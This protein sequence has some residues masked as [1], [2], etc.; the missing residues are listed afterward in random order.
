MKKQ[1]LKCLACFLVISIAI[2]LLIFNRNMFLSLGGQEQVL[3]W[4]AT[5][6]FESDKKGGYIL[7]SGKTGTLKLSGMKGELGYMYIDIGA[8]DGDG[9]TAPIEYALVISDEGNSE[10]YTLPKVNMYP[11]IEKTKYVCGDSYGDVK[12]MKIY[13]YAKSDITVTID[14]IAYNVKVPCFFS[15]I[16]VI[17][18][19]SIMMLLWS[20]RPTSGLYN[21]SWDRGIKA[22]VVFSVLIINIAILFVLV[23]SNVSFLDPGWAHHKQYHKLAVA[24]TKGEVSIPIGIEDEISKLSNPY[25][26]SLR[27][28]VKNSSLGW[29]T[30]FYE[31]KFYVY[32][33]IVPVLIFYLPFYVITGKAFPTWL[34]IF[35]MGVAVLTGAFYLMRQLVRKYFKE[36]P[37]MLYVVLSVIFGNSMNVI[38]F[39]LRPD[40][41]TLPIMCALAFSIWGLGFWI[42]AARM[43]EEKKGHKVKVLLKLF[44]GSFCLAL[45]AGCRPQFLLGSFLVFFIFERCIKEEFKNDRKRLIIN[46]VVA[47]IPY[48]VIAAGLMY[49][50]YVRFGSP[51]DFGA[52]YNLTTNDMTR[53]GFELGRVKDG[54]FMY[55][56]Q[57]PNIGMKFPYVFSTGFQSSNIA[58]TIRESMYGGVLFTNVILLS[59]FSLRR[60]KKPLKEK[61]LYK[62]TVS[63]IIFAVI[64]VVADT[65]MAGILSRYY[66]DFT[67]LLL[68]AAIIV[69]L[70]LWESVNNIKLR[71]KLLTFIIVSG[72]CGICMQFAIGIQAGG[73]ISYNDYWY[74]CVQSF[75]S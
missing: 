14:K 56:F 11:D 50:N 13:I 23:Q 5:N 29:D 67:W 24:L 61:K 47:I 16:R 20:I 52:N 75:L 37:F 26:G 17:L 68:I 64:I 1:I 44:A 4:E 48:I 12:D 15:I 74:Y 70:Q 66:G 21:R 25:D 27:G 55:L 9:Y 41:Y 53:R 73:L 65:Q 32:F 31:G 8:V 30:A 3:K 35:I 59:I 60:V 7:K 62:M 33:G 2:E 40:Y 34:G 72:L 57:F 36:T 22:V 69:I 42:G 18:L 19:F 28:Q 58:T 38:M 45:V 6:G 51:F 39:M 43:W 10:M 49:Y 46:T 63:S 54:V 71:R